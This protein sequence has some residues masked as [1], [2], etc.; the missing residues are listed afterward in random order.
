M[1][2]VQND[3]QYSFICSQLGINEVGI[4]KALLNWAQEHQPEGTLHTFYITIYHTTVL[5]IR[6][7]SKEMISTRTRHNKA[8]TCLICKVEQSQPSWEHV[9]YR[10]QRVTA[11]NQGHE[12][13]ESKPIPTG[14]WCFWS[15]FIINLNGTDKRLTSSFIGRC[16][17]FP[18]QLEL[19]G[20]I[21]I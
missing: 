15:D 7:Q 19:E 5:F 6:Q 16:F 17:P 20:G 10:T 11:W 2:L 8:K 1:V 14:I 3:Q 21:S 12:H 13:R 9:I 4:Q 18:F